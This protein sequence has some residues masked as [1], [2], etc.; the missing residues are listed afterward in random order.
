M[1]MEQ[2]IVVQPNSIIHIIGVFEGGGAKRDFAPPKIFNDAI[3]RKPAPPLPL[4]TL[5]LRYTY[6]TVEHDI[7]A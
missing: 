3:T 1:H 6:D 2:S 4:Q 5:P 7:V